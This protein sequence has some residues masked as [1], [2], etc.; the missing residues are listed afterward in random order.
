MREPVRPNQTP[1]KPPVKP[2]FDKPS[3]AK[4]EVPD[5][6]TDAYSDIGAKHAPVKNSKPQAKITE[7]QRARLFAI[8]HSR[9][10]MGWTEENMRTI[11][12]D[13]YGLEST[14]DIHIGGMYDEIVHLI[15]TK[16]YFE[17]YKLV[18][19]Q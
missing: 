19:K 16:D 9:V 18:L 1:Q 3:H 5:E 17:A 15:E 13:G 12:R 2:Q 6:P 8:Q 10:G 11:L 7:K 4:V 14:K